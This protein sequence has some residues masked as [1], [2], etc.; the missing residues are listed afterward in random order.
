MEEKIIEKL[1]KLLNK[2][3]SAK[4]IGN[5]EE[6]EAFALKITEMLTK[7]NLSILDVKAEKEKNPVTNSIFTDIKYKKNEGLWVFDMINVICQYNFGRLIVV[8]RYGGKMAMVFAEPAEIEI[9]KFISEQLISKYKFLCSR[10]INEFGNS[11]GLKK[12]K[13]KRDFYKGAVLGLSSKYKEMRAND[14]KEN[15]K[16]TGLVLYKKENIDRAFN[17]VFEPDDV[18][19][20]RSRKLD[21]NGAL[22]MGFKAGYETDINK[23]LNTVANNQR[24][25]S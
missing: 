4:D 1:R 2:H 19:K 3:E 22:N 18:G 9:I 14:I 12:N 25:N 20:Q 15:E 23:G 24:L 11:V 10:A 6:A 16:V 5:L 17:E 21:I 8:N 13:F 7:Y